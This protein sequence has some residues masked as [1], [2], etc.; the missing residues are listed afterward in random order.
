MLV[1]FTSA[2]CVAT[3]LMSRALSYVD[4]YRD[5]P[6]ELERMPFKKKKQKSL[7]SFDTN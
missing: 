2:I 3:F 1:L 4:P 6:P 7:K 5:M